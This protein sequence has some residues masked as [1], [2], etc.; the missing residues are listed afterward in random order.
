MP[1]STAAI[2]GGAGRKHRGEYYGDRG[3]RG[4]RAHRAAQGYA[5]HGPLKRSQW[6]GV[7]DGNGIPWRV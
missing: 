1:R 3:R 7:K 2:F 5:G 4:G 6:H